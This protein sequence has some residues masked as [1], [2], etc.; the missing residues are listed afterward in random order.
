MKAELVKVVLSNYLDELKLFQKDI[1]RLESTLTD[2]EKRETTGGK[3]L[4]KL[5]LSISSMNTLVND[6]YNSHLKE[7]GDI[8][9]TNS[10]K[11]FNDLIKLLNQYACFD[12]LSDP[13]VQKLKTDMKKA[14]QG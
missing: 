7:R 5:L 10:E 2:Y 8:V 11:K 13:D 12:S 4:V 9:I 1:S 3:F 14:L 6:F